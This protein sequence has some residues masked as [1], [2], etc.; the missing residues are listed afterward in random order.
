MS[1]R[2]KRATE[3]ALAEVMAR[4]LSELDVAVVMVDGIEVAGQCCGRT[5]HLC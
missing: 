4:D 3:A 2:W 5:C 1:R